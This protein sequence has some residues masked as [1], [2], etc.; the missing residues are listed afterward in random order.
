MAIQPADGVHA[1]I[2]EVASVETQTGH[3]MG[4]L[5]RQQVDF[6]GKLDAA[7]GV[8]MD[9]RTHAVLLPRQFADSDNVVDHPLPVGG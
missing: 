4:N 7:A 1:R 9:N 3:L 8:R 6:I 2:V 5:R